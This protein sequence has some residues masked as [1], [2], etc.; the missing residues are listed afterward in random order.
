MR[1]VLQ[2]PAGP[3]LQRDDCDGSL[4]IAWKVAQ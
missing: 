2:R 4:P 3:A 1:I